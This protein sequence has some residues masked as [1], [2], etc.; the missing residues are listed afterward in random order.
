[1]KKCIAILFL[2][3]V[4]SAVS[5][6]AQ[7]TNGAPRRG[8]DQFDINEG[9]R[10]D[11]PRGQDGGCAGSAS[12]VGQSGGF[13]SGGGTSGGQ[14]SGSQDR[15]TVS[16]PRRQPER[17]DEQTYASVRQMVQE[18]FSIEKRY[19]ASIYNS[20]D[21]CAH[22]VTEILKQKLESLNKAID[23]LRVGLLDQKPLRDVWNLELLNRS[24]EVISH[25]MLAMASIKGDRVECTGENKMFCVRYYP[26]YVS[27]GG[28]I[29]KQKLIAAMLRVVKINF[30]ALYGNVL[31]GG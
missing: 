7:S 16:T 3:G 31:I 13:G 9:V 29:E 30:Q 11:A 15:F 6:Y 27:T 23:L 20:V 12:G 4:G 5:S 18:G 17:L 26:G 22:V 28:S 25:I 8:L 14:G 19:R 1:M 10:V 24:Q 2:V 21:P